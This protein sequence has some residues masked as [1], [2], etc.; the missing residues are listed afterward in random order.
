[1][2]GGGVIVH[3]AAGRQVWDNRLAPRLERLWPELRRQLAA[4]T[5]L[6]SPGESTGSA[7]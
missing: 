2:S 4:Q 7:L 6:L 1:M 5:G 3:D